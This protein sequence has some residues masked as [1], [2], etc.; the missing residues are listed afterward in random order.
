MLEGCKNT[1]YLLGYSC[2]V[3]FSNLLS[4]QYAGHEIHIDLRGRRGRKISRQKLNLLW[5]ITHPEV[6]MLEECRA[7]NHVFAASEYFASY[8]RAEGLKNVST[9]LQVF[10]IPTYSTSDWYNATSG[11]CVR[12]PH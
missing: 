5:I 1:S 9:L 6:V 10:S 11:R 4:K 3:F 12:G 8:L 2:D 7:Y